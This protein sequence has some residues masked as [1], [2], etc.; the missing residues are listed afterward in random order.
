MAI[1]EEG[2]KNFGEKFEIE[3]FRSPDLKGEGRKIYWED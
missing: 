3:R 2:C 1:V